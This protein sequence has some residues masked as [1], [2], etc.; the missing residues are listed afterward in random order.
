VKVIVDGVPYA[1]SSKPPTREALEVLN[2]DLMR[3]DL[4]GMRSTQQLMTEVAA[5]QGASA[6]EAMA[7][8]YLMPGQRLTAYFA[9]WE[10]GQRPSFRELRSSEIQIEVEPGDERPRPKD[11][12]APKSRG[13]KRGTTSALKS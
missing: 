5:L 7:S 1:V 9:L 12:A 8:P 10:A 2:E 4:P 6:E 3:M 13:R 11:H